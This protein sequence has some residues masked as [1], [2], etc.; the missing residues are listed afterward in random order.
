MDAMKA[1]ATVQVRQDRISLKHARRGLIFES[2]RSPVS[3]G[4]LSPLG[5]TERN[6]DQVQMPNLRPSIGLQ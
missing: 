5:V 4:K 3:S 2:R 6:G 1:A